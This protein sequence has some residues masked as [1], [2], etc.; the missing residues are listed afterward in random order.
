MMAVGPSEAE[1]FRT[2][3]LRGLARRGLRGV[4]LV[5]SDAHE[6][7][8]AAETCQQ[9]PWPRRLACKMPMPCRIS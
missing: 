2:D 4:K 9:R 6:G 3:F 5:V 1:T 8:K 7:L